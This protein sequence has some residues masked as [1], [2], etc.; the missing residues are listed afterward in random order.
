MA[1]DGGGDGRCS[2]GSVSECTIAKDC[3]LPLLGGDS[4]FLDGSGRRD[5]AVLQEVFSEL[6]FGP[7]GGD[8][9]VKVISQE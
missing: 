6:R 1:V 4:H 5:D 9:S 7:S 3:N 2:R 8:E